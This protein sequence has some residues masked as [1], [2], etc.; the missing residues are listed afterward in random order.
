MPKSVEKKKKRKE[1]RKEVVV[2]IPPAPWEK[3]KEEVAPLK[4]VVAEAKKK[5]IAKVAPQKRNSAD[6]P[7]EIHRFPFRIFSSMLFAAW[8]IFFLDQLTKIVAQLFLQPRGQISFGLVGLSYTTN[9][10]AAFSVFADMT[11]VL[12]ILSFVAVQVLIFLLFITYFFPKAP[13]ARPVMEFLEKPGHTAMY[14]LLLGGAAGNLFD[15]LFRG[16]VI[17]FIE[18]SYFA[19]FNIADSALTIAVIF[20]AL[21][22]AILWWKDRK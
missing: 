1:K 20:L 2:P 21:E 18:V 7:P 10:G 17:D 11:V 14:T 3:A 22:S 9:T 12:T 8:L 6:T 16:Y 15:R 5:V 13:L 19:T 4:V